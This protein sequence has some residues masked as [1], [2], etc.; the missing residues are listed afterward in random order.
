VTH[1]KGASLELA[2]AL[3]TN[4]SLDWKSHL[5]TI[6][7]LLRSLINYGRKKFYNIGPRCQCYVTFFFVAKVAL[8]QAIMQSIRPLFSAIAI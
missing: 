7:S 1:I 3:P 4:I 2:L 8:T 5:V 6:T